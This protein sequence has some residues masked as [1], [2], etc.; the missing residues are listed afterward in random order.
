MLST[1]RNV[2]RID[3]QITAD[4]YTFETAKEFVYFGSAV[5]TKNDVS[6]EIKRRVTLANLQFSNRDLS[7]WIILVCS[8][9]IQGNLIA[10]QVTELPGEIKSPKK[11]FS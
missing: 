1:S 8:R 6:L 10:V 3:S 2:R 9:N 5:T 4:K 11:Y 7:L